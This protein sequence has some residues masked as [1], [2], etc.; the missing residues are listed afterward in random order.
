[1]RKSATRLHR[2]RRR[3]VR[4]RRGIDM[5]DGRPSC[6]IL[7]DSAAQLMPNVSYTPTA[8]DKGKQKASDSECY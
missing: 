7:L 3:M 4:I 1:M 2:L 5:E 8:G 6:L